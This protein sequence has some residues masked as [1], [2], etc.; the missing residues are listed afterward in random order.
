MHLIASTLSLDDT[1]DPPCMTLT[2][3]GDGRLISSREV[4]PAAAMALLT[5]LAGD[6]PDTLARFTDLLRGTV[7]RLSD[8]V[9]QQAREQ[10][11]AVWRDV[12]A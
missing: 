6:Q 7:D 11:L 10:A 3:E 4:T 1:A 5:Q 12:I 2:I 9:A 8:T